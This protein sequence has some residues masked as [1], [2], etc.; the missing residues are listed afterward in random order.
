MAWQLTR[1]KFTCDVTAKAVPVNSLH[2]HRRARSI[3][4]EDPC[5]TT[6]AGLGKSLGVN[7]PTPLFSPP[8]LRPSTPAAYAEGWGDRPLW[9]KNS[10]MLFKI[11]ILKSL[12]KI[13]NRSNAREKDYDPQ[14]AHTQM[15]RREFVLGL[16]LGAGRRWDCFCF[17]FVHLR[18]S[19]KLGNLATNS[20]SA[21]KTNLFSLL[22]FFLQRLVRLPL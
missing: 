12:Q 3:S 6:R 9:L 19:S 17:R 16:T 1:S 18:A 14:L 20:S 13:L 22:P 11:R 21:K 15:N 5:R 4:W 10:C 2:S 8:P 7:P